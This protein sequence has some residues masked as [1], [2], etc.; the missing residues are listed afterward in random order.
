MNS[1]TGKTI[2]W[3]LQESVVELELHL[4]PGNEIGTEMLGELEQ[5]ANE[6]DTF[7]REACALIIHSSL[8]SVFSAGADLRELYRSALPLDAAARVAGIREF[9]HRIHT[10]L[11]ALDDTP[12]TTI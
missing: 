5:F 11:N 9:L 12:L 10:V 4:A 7:S 1:F 6:L 3:T 8:P 2:S